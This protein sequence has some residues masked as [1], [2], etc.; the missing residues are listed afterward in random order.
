[1]NDVQ[2]HH[3]ALILGRARSSDD[4]IQMD[5]LEALERVAEEE[6][7]KSGLPL[8][9]FITGAP[10]DDGT[11][12]GTLVAG[13]LLA[14]AVDEDGPEQIAAGRIDEHRSTDIPRDFF[15]ALAAAG[16]AFDGPGSTEGVFLVPLGWSTARLTAAPDDEAV[17]V[18]TAERDAPQHLLL[19]DEL[20]ARVS[21][22]R[23]P[24]WL[25]A[26]YC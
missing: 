9:L 6:G 21:A 22:E 8:V 17:H 24:L 14:Y 7:A 15:G 25:E 5:R 23:L 19:P 13:L 4:P 2:E 12:L 26:D 10:L 3:A 16:F 18:T 1:M 11:A 20:V